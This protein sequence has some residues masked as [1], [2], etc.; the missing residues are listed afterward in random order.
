MIIYQDQDLNRQTLFQILD[1]I[2]FKQAGVK[3]IDD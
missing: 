3:E 1:N 2:Y